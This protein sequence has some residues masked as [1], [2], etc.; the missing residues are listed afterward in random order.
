M[1]L[2][3]SHHPALIVT[4]YNEAAN[5]ELLLSSILT[6]HLK[7]S[8]VVIVDG[9]STDS[10]VEI[11]K[12]YLGLGNHHRPRQTDKMWQIVNTDILFKVMVKR[13]NRSVG[14][15][16]AARQTEAEWIAITDAGCLLHKNWLRELWRVVEQSNVV[17]RAGQ[18]EVVAGYYQAD[19]MTAFEEAV[20]PY[21]LVMPDRVD[22]R[23]FLPAT[24]SMMIKKS[25]LEA[26]GGFDE[27]LSDNE[28]YDLARR[29]EAAGHQMR[30][31]RKAL[32]TWIPRSTW[33]GFFVM[34]FRFARG[35]VYAGLIRPKMLSV[36][37][38]YLLWLGVLGWNGWWGVGLAMIYLGW[39]IKKNQKYVPH[40]WYLLPLLQ[41][42]A[43]G[44]VMVGS[45][46]GVGQR[47]LAAGKRG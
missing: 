2:T 28:D 10:T 33:R 47:I 12:T 37:G 7:P 20:V 29:L 46:A 24:R 11:I 15:N 22:E 19:P 43:D 32:V 34:L 1:K 8:E 38:R 31:A 27:R 4:V 42:V 6:Q 36:F 5:I 45:L 21:V 41:I 35:D 13:G 14:R 39:A 40:G 16:W 44:A 26:V 17:G 9:G 3:N 23:H 25:V 18:V 30:F